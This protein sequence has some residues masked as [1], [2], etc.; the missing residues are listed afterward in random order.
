MGSQGNVSTNSLIFN[1]RIWTL[2]LLHPDHLKLC[3]VYLA[4]QININ[5]P[6]SSWNRESVRMEIVQTA[7]PVA[8]VVKRIAIN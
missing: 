5:S 3:S 4:E 1:W 6:V 2:A 8:K 7:N